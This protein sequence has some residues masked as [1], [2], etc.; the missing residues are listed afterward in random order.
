MLWGVRT[1]TELLI[2][3]R[4]EVGLTRASEGARRLQ[5]LSRSAS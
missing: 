1:S 4:A 3:M 2:V 5:R